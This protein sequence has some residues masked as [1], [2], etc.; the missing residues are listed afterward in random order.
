MKYYQPLGSE[1]ENASYANCDPVNHVWENSMPDARGFEA[2]QR[3]IVNAI[4][5]AVITPDADDNAQLA[6][7]IQRIV[8]GG[9][10]YQSLYQKL[11][12]VTG[13]N[14]VL[15]DEK[16]IGWAE[17][18]S[19]TSFSFDCTN[20]SKKADGDI[21]TFELYI[22]MPT[23]VVINWPAITAETPAET[24]DGEPTVTTTP[25]VEWGDDNA[26]DMSDPGLYLLTFRSL[27]H[28]ATWEGSVQCKFKVLPA[29]ASETVEN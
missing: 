22:D 29:P 17:V 13:G 11:K 3:E 8:N 4:T 21:I 15:D 14:V 23:P 26:P 20:V 18:S 12:P 16:I 2:C 5:A 27:N 1:D 25:L 7:A 6:T 19:E 24:E 28:G 9:I 10:R